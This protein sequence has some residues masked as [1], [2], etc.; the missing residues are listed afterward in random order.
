MERILVTGATG[1]IG[2]N[3][4]SGL[5]K[6]QGA[7]VAVVTRSKADTSLLNSVSG[8][9]EVF[10]FNNDQDLFEVI[11]HFKPTIVVHIAA[12]F[13]ADDEQID[14]LQILDGN[15]DFGVKILFHAIKHG[16]KAFINTC[17]YWQ[18]DDNFQRVASNFY[19]ASKNAF[20]E[21]LIH[22]QINHKISVINLVLFD[23]YGY[24]DPRPKLISSL[25]K[26]IEKREVVQL[27]PGDQKLDLVH[28]NDVVNAFTTATKMA[29]KDTKLVNA[30][31]NFFTVRSGVLLSLKEIIE[32]YCKEFDQALF[33][34][35]GSKPYRKNE[36]MCPPDIHAPLPHWKCTL[37]PKSGI[38]KTIGEYRNTMP[39][40]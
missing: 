4:T 19:S 39:M 26:L 6:T 2:A 3:V 36:L 12:S 5:V 37:S 23:V 7:S 17:S 20:I 14:L 24:G 25:P 38:F 10:E 16:M 1:F 22:A 32:I 18:F 40:E 13:A 15:V 8:Q 29:M 11:G 31:S 35:F 27:S 34:D 21:F 30:A 9:I 33:F 28:I